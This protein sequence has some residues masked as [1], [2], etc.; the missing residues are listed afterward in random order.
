MLKN[1]MLIAFTGSI[2]VLALLQLLFD[3]LSPS[4]HSLKA[5]NTRARFAEAKVQWDAANIKDYAFEI[6]GS[7]QNI[8]A[9][10]AVIEVRGNVVTQVQPLN[11][12]PPL[13]PEK[14]A[15]PDWGNEIF[16]CDYNHFT[17]PQM[18][19]MVGKTLQNSPFAIL[20]AEFD[21]RYGFI[22][23]FKDGVLGNNGWLH[24]IA[25]TIYNEF[26]VVNFQPR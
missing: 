19:V 13:P 1:K 2:L 4:L 18:L 25:R 20:E 16:L 12:A 8:C 17:V 9:V 3:P 11:A 26:Q 23:N 21:P 5:A 14:W 22:T 24:P 10:D 7:S 6:R 15:D